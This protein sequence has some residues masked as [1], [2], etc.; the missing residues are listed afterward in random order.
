MTTPLRVLTFVLALVAVFAGAVGLGAAV[1][2]L[3]EPA[4]ASHAAMP[5]TDPA[6]G[7]AATPVDLPVDLPGGL[8]V[9]EGGYTLRLAEQVLDAGRGVAL[10]FRVDGPD[11]EPL[12][13]YDVDHEKRLHLVAVRR[14]GTGFQHVHPTMAPDGT[15]T[16]ALDLTPG[17][18]RV[19]ADF[20]PTGATGLTLG[21][22]LSVAGDHAPVPPPPESTT[23]RVGR[24][25]ITLEGMLTAGEASTLTLRVSRDGAPVTD[26]EPYLGAYGHL[27]AL[28]EGDL[29]YLHVHPEE[30]GE[31]G[32]QVPFVAEVPTAG[33]YR[34]YLDFKHG[35]VVRT[36]AL[37]VS[38]SGDG[39]T[40]G[41]D[42]GDESDE[43][44]GHGH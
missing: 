16:T 41:H 40:T 25:T 21:A 10:S 30:T 19:F 28:R 12:T 5:D 38:T 18:W 29:A 37:V 39:S 42:E 3:D 31:A 11:G 15:W 7:H 43:G 23:T 24:Y 20:N 44:D 34:L 9:S 14:D 13:A 6:A 1:G 35:G 32:P 36:A 4:P 27:V 8:Q 17:G 26:L 2:P 22:D 33:R